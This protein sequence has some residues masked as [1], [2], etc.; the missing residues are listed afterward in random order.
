M[1]TYNTYLDF[2]EEACRLAQMD[3]SLSADVTQAKAY[4]N[5]AYLRVCAGP[6]EWDFLRQDGQITLTA[7]S[8]VYTHA[9]IA[10]AL[11]V[12]YID[13]ILH[14]VNDTTGYGPLASMDWD[15]LEEYAYS[16]QDSDPR[17]EPMSWAQWNTR[18]RLYPNPNRAY[19]MG[20]LV[21]LRPAAMSSD[22]EEPLLPAAHR[23]PVLVNY[24]AAKLLQIQGGGEALNNAREFMA[25][26]ERAV[27]EMRAA[28]ASANAQNIRVVHPNLNTGLPGGSP[29]VPWL[30]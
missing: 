12:T 22:T 30:L 20:V 4:V 3:T 6:D 19:V 1:A 13:R 18:I 25:D 23:R 2:A 10:T 21:R 24:A 26:H 16:T 5:E 15:A 8:D 11:S 9:A 29:S 17:G 28:H 27:R 14:I 7:G